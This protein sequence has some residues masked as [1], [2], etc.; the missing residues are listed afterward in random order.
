MR[1][2]VGILCSEIR[3]GLPEQVTGH[4]LPNLPNRLLKFL[5]LSSPFYG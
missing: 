2:D 3:K 4:P 1:L 5:L